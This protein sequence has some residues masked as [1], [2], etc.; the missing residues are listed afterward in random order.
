MYNNTRRVN[1][2]VSDFPGVFF[3]VENEMVRGV[4]HALFGWWFSV[5]LAHHVTSSDQSIGSNGRKHG[6][7]E[8]TDRA[9]EQPGKCIFF[10]SS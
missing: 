5:C 4:D 8:V 6:R 10:E 9:I 1:I 2:Q 3:S 7:V